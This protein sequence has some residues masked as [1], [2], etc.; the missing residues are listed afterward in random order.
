MMMR[1]MI[2]AA[3]GLS[4]K[5][6]KT[7]ATLVLV[8]ATTMP[9]DDA[10]KAPATAQ[11][12]RPILTT[13]LNGSVLSRQMISSAR[14]KH[15]PNERQKTVRQACGSS[16]SRMNKPPVLKINDEVASSTTARAETRVPGGT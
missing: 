2:A 7:M 10:L 16:S 12:G 9:I 11:P 1:A 13:A 8:R 4:A 3:N 5:I 6:T 15:A 14:L